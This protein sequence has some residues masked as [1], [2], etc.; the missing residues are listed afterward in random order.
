I[1]PL[2]SILF[3][4][5]FISHSFFTSISPSS[6]LSCFDTSLYWRRSYHLYYSSSLLLSSSRL[7]SS[8]SFCLSLFSNLSSSLLSKCIHQDVHTTHS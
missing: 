4:S 7:F 8:F 1:P 3:L 5:I 2:L 6:S